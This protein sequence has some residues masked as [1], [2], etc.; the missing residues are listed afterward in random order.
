MPPDLWEA[1]D[2]CPDPGNNPEL[3]PTRLTFTQPDRGCLFQRRAGLVGLQQG[4]VATP[5]QRGH[6]LPAGPGLLSALQEAFHV[7]RKEFWPLTKARS[8]INKFI[9]QLCH[10]SDGLIFQGAQARRAS[11][12]QEDQQPGWAAPAGLQLAA[13]LIPPPLGTLRCPLQQAALIDRQPADPSLISG[14]VPLQAPTFW[15]PA[16][17][18]CMTLSTSADVLPNLPLPPPPPPLSTRRQD[19][20]VPGTCQELLKWKFAHMNSVDFRLRRHPRTSE[21]QLELLET[22]RDLAGMPDG[23]HRGYNALPGAAWPAGSTRPPCC[24]LLGAILLERSSPGCLASCFAL[25][26]W[27]L[28]HPHPHQHPLPQTPLPPTPPTPTPPPTPGRLRRRA[29]GVPP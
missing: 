4:A 6:A 26:P 18:P 9:P 3:Q 16:H 8:L 20:Y 14:I 28:P 27:P 7:R 5:T 29:G 12:R 24:M 13:S 17:A 15:A 11:S 22:R 25:H 10:E 1:S 23:W 21:W 2:E 19:A